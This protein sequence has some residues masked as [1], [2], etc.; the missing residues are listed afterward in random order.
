MIAKK[1]ENS[2]RAYIRAGRLFKIKS[3]DLKHSTQYWTQLN[4]IEATMSHY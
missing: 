4:F 1:N 3:L 2:L